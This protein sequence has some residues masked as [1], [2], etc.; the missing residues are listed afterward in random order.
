M[1]SWLNPVL[2]EDFESQVRSLAKG[3]LDEREEL[4]TNS[5]R[6]HDLLT[7]LGVPAED[8][9]L[10]TFAAIVADSAHLPMGKQREYWDEAALEAK[11]AQIAELEAYWTAQGRES[12]EAITARFARPPVP[13][14][15]SPLNESSLW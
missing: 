9:A 5:R 14:N 2:R 15:D 11:D 13:P 12:C 7:D 8:S 3:I 1:N 10:Q 4:V 6:M